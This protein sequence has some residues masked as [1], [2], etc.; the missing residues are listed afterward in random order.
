M[1]QLETVVRQDALDRDTLEQQKQGLLE[2]HKLLNERLANV[3]SQ[4]QMTQ[5]KMISLQTLHDSVIRKNESMDKAL[6][7][8]NKR[9]TTELLNN[10][11]LTNQ[12]ASESERARS[13]AHQLASE[14]L[15]LKHLLNKLQRECDGHQQREV[16]LNTELTKLT[17]ERSSLQEKVNAL[18]SELVHQKGQ[19]VSQSLQIQRLEASNAL[20]ESQ[21]E[22]FK[23][24]SLEL[25]KAQL[26]EARQENDGLNSQLTSLHSELAQSMRSWQGK[27]EQQHSDHNQV[28]SS[29]T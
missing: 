11:R 15:S 26:E 7:D 3:E 27:L 9:I 20:V 5:H 18:N 16:E 23:R 2:N 12:L 8:A 29:S 21:S 1:I 19:C 25:F 4:F 13:E 28:S 14:M 17:Q 24:E 10:E 6:T 22:A